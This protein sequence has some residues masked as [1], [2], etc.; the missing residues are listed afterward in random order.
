MSKII[1]E[2]L[3]VRTLFGGWGRE[4]GVF[5]SGE[6]VCY[7]FLAENRARNGVTI[8]VAFKNLFTLGTSVS[9]SDQTMSFFTPFPYLTSKKLCH[10]YVDKN[11]NK[12]RMS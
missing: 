5:P 12:K 7:V 1:R 3:F 11:S 8:V 9:I 2:I 4:S 6:G 10:H